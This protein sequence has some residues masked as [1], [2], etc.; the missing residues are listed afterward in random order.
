MLG[1]LREW[2]E[3]IKGT[4]KQEYF[5]DYPTDESI[6]DFKEAL[7]KTTVTA[8]ELSNGLYEIVRMIHW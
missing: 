7:S 4:D 6:K 8:H 2:V 5:F 1:L 3:R